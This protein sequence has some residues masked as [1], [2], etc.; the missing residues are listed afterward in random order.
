[1]RFLKLGLFVVVATSLVANAYFYVLATQYKESLTNQAIATFH[2]EMLLRAYELNLTYDEVKSRLTKK[3]PE[4]ISEV[5]V[6]KI[7]E[8]IITDV[9]EKALVIGSTK[10]YFKNG[11]YYGSQV[12]WPKLLTRPSI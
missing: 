10:L 3:V 7:P 11:V 12:A 6:T 2:I 5:A 9:D 1:M 8:L 4:T